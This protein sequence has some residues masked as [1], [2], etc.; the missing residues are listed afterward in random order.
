MKKLFT[1][2][3]L[4]VSVSFIFGQTSIYVS[5]FGNDNNDGTMGSP[6]LAVKLQMEMEFHKFT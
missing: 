5:T 6:Y 3:I 1:V 4:L 2:L